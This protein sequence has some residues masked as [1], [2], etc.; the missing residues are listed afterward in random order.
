MKSQP[1]QSHS[2]PGMERGPARESPVFLGLGTSDVR[3]LGIGS[4]EP[5]VAPPDQQWQV[6]SSYPFGISLSREDYWYK[7]GGRE[8]ERSRVTDDGLGIPRSRHISSIL[9][10]PTLTPF[11]ESRRQGSPYYR[12]RIFFSLSD[13]PKSYFPSQPDLFLGMESSWVSACGPGIRTG[14]LCPAKDTTT[15]SMAIS[16]VD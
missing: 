3:L 7:N 16:R 5:A 10:K 6:R 14:P 1:E 12:I 13:W 8:G 15:T 4:V 9:Q 11:Y 2:L